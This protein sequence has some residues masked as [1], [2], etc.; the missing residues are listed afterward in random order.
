MNKL[1]FSDGFLFKTGERIM[2]GAVALSVISEHFSRYLFASKFCQDKVALDVACGCGYGSKILIKKAREVYSVDISEEL[3]AFGNIRYG[4]HNN[5]FLTMDA[6]KLKFPNNYF[7]VIV[8][9]ET[10]EHLPHHEKFLSEC[11][12]VLK[13]D[14]RFILS[15]P[16]KNITSPGRAK[17]YNKYHYHEWNIQELTKMISDNFGIAALYGQEYMSPNILS[18]WQLFLLRMIQFLVG[19]MPALVMKILKKHIFHYK[20]E[21]FDKFRLDKKD[22]IKKASEKDFLLNNQE[23]AF[24][25]IIMILKKRRNVYA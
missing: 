15:T 5:H 2:P 21:D 4:R 16:N 23:R 1:R 17:P 13:D 8:S 11:F 12:R 24:G 20:E 19:L 7:D 22:I 25:I 18:H 14:G 10:L 6:Q 3:V 9:F